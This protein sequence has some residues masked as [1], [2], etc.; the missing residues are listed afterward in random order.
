MKEQDPRETPEE[1]EEDIVTL[2]DESGR[3]VTFDHLL[4]VEYEGASYI[5]L[6][7]Q[8]DMDENGED[9]YAT[10]EDEE[11]YQKVFQKCLDIMEEQDDEADDDEADSDDDEE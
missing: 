6:E 7:A 4:T 9:V 10:I 3:D 5:L 1:N 8:Q 2:Q 11:E